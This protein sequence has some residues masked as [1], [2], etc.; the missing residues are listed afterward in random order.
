MGDGRAAH[1]G[2]RGGREFYGA[3]FGWELEPVAG[4]P[5]NLWRLPG[6][7]GGAPGQPIPRDVVAVATLATDAVPP[8]WAVNFRVDDVDGTCERAVDGGGTL[9][10]PPTEAPRVPQR[11]DRRP[12]GRRGRDQRAERCV[13]LATGP[14]PDGGNG[15]APYAQALARSVTQTACCLESSLP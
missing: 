1:A 9:L 8:H 6:Y 12:A 11:G 13:T 2:S 14:P 4:A 15:S 7:V 10:M 5:L 3:L